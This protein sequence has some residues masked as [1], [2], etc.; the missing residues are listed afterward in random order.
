MRKLRKVASDAQA[1]LG[2]MLTI[3]DESLTGLRI[4]KAFN[5]IG[6]VQ[7]KFH[8]QN[9]RYS[10]V[11]RKIAKR[12]ELASPMSEL[13]GVVVVIGILIYGGSMVLAGD[14]TLKPEEFVAYAAIFSQVLRPAK[15]ITTSFTMIQQGVI[16]GERVLELIDLKPAIQNKP[17]AATIKG[18]HKEI[19]FRNVSFSYGHNEVLKDISFKIPK[20]KTIA[21]VGPSGGGKSTIS[22]LIPRFYDPQGGGIYFDGVNIQDC[23]MESLREQMGIVNQESILFN[24]TLFNNIAF[25]RPNA[26]E[27]EVM[28]AA[29]VANAHNFIMETEHG[30]NTSIGDRGMK[31]SGG[32][33]QRISIARAVLKNPPI[34]ILDEATSALDTESEKLVQEALDKLMENRTSLVIAH[35]LS[36]I[37]N[38]DLILVID[39]GKI[40]ESGTHSEL[41]EAHLGL[42]KKLK[43]MQTV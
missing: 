24:D 35:R 14:N 13:L 34:L 8:H 36:T 2:V 20:G 18:F 4:V 21:L 7:D 1:S 11:S 42:Y 3:I 12:N 29:K 30:Y 5:A 31:L 19:E 25:S 40:I 17:D 37:Q 10:I 39:N 23:T 15:A 28:N 6:Y 27:E 9:L 32:Q 22:D 26:T 16:A 43:M 41:L 33:K 38:A